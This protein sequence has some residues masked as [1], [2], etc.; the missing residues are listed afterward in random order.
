M[1]PTSTTAA[2]ARK[3][4]TVPLRHRIEVGVRAFAAV[5]VG[6]LLA[7]GSTAFLT[8]VLP[9]SRSDR[10]VAASLLCFAVWCAAAMYAFA[11]KSAARAVLAPLLLALALY[12]VALA[13]PEFAARP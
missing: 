4:K 13:F 1:S 8:V 6:Y 10:V 7:Y 2:P 9:F 11:A 12:G 3:A 5:V